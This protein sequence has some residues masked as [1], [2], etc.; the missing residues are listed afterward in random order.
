M[1]LK[2]K[3]FVESIGLKCVTKDSRDRLVLALT[4]IVDEM[5]GDFEVLS[6]ALAHELA[7]VADRAIRSEFANDRFGAHTHNLSRL[8]HTVEV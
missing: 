3:Y 1:V 5:L 4:Q 2:T 8:F 6:S 7:A